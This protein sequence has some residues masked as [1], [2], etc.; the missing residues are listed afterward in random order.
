[1]NNKIKKISIHLAILT[2]DRP[3]LLFKML[4]SIAKQKSPPESILLSDNSIKHYRL[5]KEIKQS[6][7]SLTL[8]YKKRENLASPRHFEIVFKELSKKSGYSV[9]VHDDD[10]LDSNYIKEVS[11]WIHRYPK[12]KILATNSFSIKKTMTIPLNYY[13]W[14][15]KLYKIQTL[16]KSYINLKNPVFPAIIYHNSILLEAANLQKINDKIFKKYTDMVLVSELVKKYNLLY[17][18]KP[19]YFYRFHDLNDSAANDFKSRLNIVKYLRENKICEGIINQY[20]IFN[21]IEERRFRKKRINK[22]LFSIIFFRTSI[23]RL[24]SL[25]LLIKYIMQ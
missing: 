23:H 6:F 11:K 10:Y 20:R 16:I 15:S 4:D 5:E 2:R 7:P 13:I 17:I 3:E 21:L 25:K 1:M 22:R 14:G 24:S 18:H 9:I 8:E 12:Q 19:L